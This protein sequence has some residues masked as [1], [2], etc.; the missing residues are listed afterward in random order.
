MSSTT[1]NEQSNF[2]L[3]MQKIP[4]PFPFSLGTDILHLPRLH[5]LILN[6]NGTCRTRFTRRVLHRLESQELHSRHPTWREGSQLSAEKL[7]PVVQ[8]I[9]G[10]W[11]AKE[12]A[13]KAIGAT[14]L[15]WKDVRVERDEATGK[16]GIIWSTPSEGIIAQEY[17]ARLSI[18]HDGDYVVATV[19]AT[20]P[21]L[22]PGK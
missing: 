6:K 11:A 15:S 7:K 2:S 3:I 9:G 14:L 5:R 22:A 16:P 20:V 19:L 1:P 4:F 12:A 8:W 17:E 10:R 13:R 18:S 21:H